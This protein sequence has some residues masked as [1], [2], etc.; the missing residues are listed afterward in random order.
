MPFV[1]ELVRFAG[2]SDDTPAPLLP[3]EAYRAEATAFPRSPELVSPDQ[4]RRP[5]EGASEELGGGVWLLPQIPG[6][7]TSK[8]GLYSIEMLGAESLSFAVCCDP[9]EGD[10]DRLTKEELDSA[11]IALEYFAR[12]VES[13]DD[14]TVG[15][16]ARGELW[17]ALCMLALAFL[18][19]EALWA[20]RLGR[21]RGIS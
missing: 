4:S 11:H 14:E 19:G 7:D 3:G 17:R 13:Q 15:D 8:V 12:D 16:E 1:H 2:S 6:S 9:N 21:R 10:L 20:A 18:I 5:L